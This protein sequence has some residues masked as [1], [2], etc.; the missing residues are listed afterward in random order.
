MKTGIV[1]AVLAFAPKVYAESDLSVDLLYGGSLS[2]EKS[3]LEPASL[4][5]A[6]AAYAYNHLL[7]FELGYS[8]VEGRYDEEGDTSLHTDVERYTATSF[9][10]KGSTE[11]S[12]S[13]SLNLRLGLAYSQLQQ[14]NYSQTLPWQSDVANPKRTEKQSASTSGLGSYYSLGIERRFTQNIYMGLDYSSFR[15]N[16]KSADFSAYKSHNITI[17][18]GYNF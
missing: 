4:Y 15:F 14:Q 7:S 3:T 11:I 1:I 13:Y 8:Q 18:L 9:G 17:S 16:A 6:R 2:S 5:G 12:T 10:I